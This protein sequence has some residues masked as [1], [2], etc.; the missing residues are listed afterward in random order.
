L[1]VFL[2]CGE[3]GFVFCTI[4]LFFYFSYTHIL[5]SIHFFFCY[6]FGSPEK[7]REAMADFIRGLGCNAFSCAT[8]QIDESSVRSGVYCL[9]P[10]EV[11]VL[12]C[13]LVT[14]PDDPFYTAL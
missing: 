10:H 9:Q 5:N 4:N 6:S 2:A 8:L 7:E 1:G 12:V 14:T 3:L 13:D 11:E